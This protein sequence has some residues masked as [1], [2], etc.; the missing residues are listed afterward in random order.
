MKRR[1]KKVRRFACAAV[2][3]AVSV[4]MALPCAAAEIPGGEIVSDDAVVSEVMDISENTGIPDEIGFSEEISDQEKY[5]VSDEMDIPDLSE[6]SGDAVSSDEIELMNSDGE[7]D[8]EVVQEEFS[9]DLSENSEENLKED[10]YYKEETALAEE[11]I[12]VEEDGL[13]RPEGLRKSADVSERTG[14]SYDDYDDYDEFL[15]NCYILTVTNQKNKG[16]ILISYEDSSFYV[17]N[18]YTECEMPKDVA[19]SV[20]VFPNPGYRVKSI[21]IEGAAF[22]EEGESYRFC[23]SDEIISVSVR[24]EKIPEE[25]SVLPTDIPSVT[26]TP[27]VTPAPTDR[28]TET[29]AITDVPSE[30]TPLPIVP[31]TPTDSAEDRPSSEDAPAETP[32]DGPTETPVITDIPS[33]GTSEETPTD[34]SVPT[35]TLTPAP[36][37]TPSMDSVP[38]GNT[39]AD[40]QVA[41]GSGDIFSRVDIFPDIFFG[42]RELQTTGGSVSSVSFDATVIYLNE[43]KPSETGDS[44]KA[45]AEKE[46]ESAPVKGDSNSSDKTVN[47]EAVSEDPSEKDTGNGTEADRTASDLESKAG[48]ETAE[49]KSSET[50]DRSSKVTVEDGAV[51]EGGSEVSSKDGISSAASAVSKKSSDRT[52]ILDSSDNAENSNLSNNRKNKDFF[53]NLK[54]KISNFKENLKGDEVKAEEE[55]NKE[56][57][58][59]SSKFFPFFPLYLSIFCCMILAKLWIKSKKKGCDV[60]G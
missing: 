9:D 3:A 47:A 1:M 18:N 17:K 26:E 55:N 41:A 57:L 2:A 5:G 31:E 54:D 21:E 29:P 33:E 15:A 7:E 8:S 46:E 48:K 42:D 36:A 50:A 13:L 51:T 53:E 27:T 37:D 19:I 16:S 11:S 4:S 20:M 32:T 40:D 45:D 56:N 43:K 14:I 60:N 38:S 59:K 44:Q 52:D 10:P 6:V 39:V 28:P 22:S 35:V 23:M 24:Y 30:D 34:T 58:K 25:E 49:K 12:P